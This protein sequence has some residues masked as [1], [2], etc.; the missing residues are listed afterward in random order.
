MRGPKKWTLFTQ[1]GSP[2]S[3]KA[4][5][6]NLIRAENKALVFNCDHEM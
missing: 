1:I 5:P 4:D 2:P 6:V 3:V